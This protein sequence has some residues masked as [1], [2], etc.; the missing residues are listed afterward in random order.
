MTTITA[1][2][3]YVEVEIDIEDIATEDLEE[4]LSR[5]CGGITGDARVALSDIYLQLKFGNDARALEMVRTFVE[6][7]MGVIL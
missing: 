1:T 2:A 7:E 3:R 6:D 5:R 4:E